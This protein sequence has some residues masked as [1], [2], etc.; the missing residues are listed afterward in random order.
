[1]GHIYYKKYLLQV[2]KVAIAVILCIIKMFLSL[3]RL[4]PDKSQI[5]ALYGKLIGYFKQRKKSILSKP[6][7]L[8]VPIAMPAFTGFLLW[9]KIR[10]V[11]GD[12]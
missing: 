3:I 2:C 4:A 10:N 9:R 7:M 8:L 12:H 11:G 5:S 1:M 6:V